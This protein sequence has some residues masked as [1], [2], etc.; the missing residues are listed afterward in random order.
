MAAHDVVV[1][2]THDIGRHQFAGETLPGFPYVAALN[3]ACAVALWRL[4]FRAGSAPLTPSGKV[5]PFE[6][7][8]AR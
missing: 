8:G 6:S 7:P 3:G 5:D 2:T 1:I 4:A